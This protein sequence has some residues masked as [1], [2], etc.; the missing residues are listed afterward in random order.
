[1]DSLSQIALGASVAHLTL[2]S[3]LGRGALLLGA[4]LGTLPDIDVLIPYDGAIANFTSHRSFSHSLFIL[5]LVSFPIAWICQFG[6]TR[7]CTRIWQ[8]KAVSYFQWWLGCW[9]VLITHPLLDGFTI[10]GT[11]LLWPLTPPPTAW[12]SAFIIDP[13]Y[14]LPLLVGVVIAYRKSWMVAKPFVI[15]GLA[16]SSC[17]LAWTLFAQSQIRHLVEEELS[18]TDV[19]ANRILIAPF[20]FSMLWR[21][22]VIT[23]SQ[24]MEGYRSLLDESNSLELD[25]Y[26]N[27]KV[28]CATWLTHAPIQRLDWFTQG[29]FALSVQNNQLIA[30]DLRM[31][32][33]DDYVFEFEIAEWENGYW[34]AIKTRQRP[35]D[36]D[37][38]RMKLL[39]KRIIE[40]DIDLTPLANN[41]R[42]V[43][44][45]CEPSGPRG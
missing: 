26:N 23:D 25:S 44:A 29:A 41:V 38:A 36:I 8:S 34:R 22:V 5:T 17:Y 27:G 37:G 24:Y 21:V 33:E 32:I 11:Q 14:T 43:P 4:A 19:K 35:I 3:R 9:L 6:Y 45:N 16:M 12:G 2:G 1:M 40:S 39:F 18:N 30:S 13:L 15:T 7:S 42:T 20:P 10:Y 31:G 28:E